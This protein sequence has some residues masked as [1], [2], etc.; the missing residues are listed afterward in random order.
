MAKVILHVAVL[1]SLISLQALLV[2]CQCRR[3]FAVEP[4]PGTNPL[5]C[6]VLEAMI[7]FT[8]TIDGTSVTIRWGFTTNSEEAGM[9]KHELD[10]ANDRYIFTTD[11]DVDSASAF[12]A[13]REFDSSYN[14]FYWCVVTNV[15]IEVGAGS[16]NPSHVLN[17]TAQHSTDELPPCEEVVEFAGTGERCA[18]GP[19]DSVLA[20]IETVEF[21]NE[22]LPTTTTEAPTTVTTETTTEE[23]TTTT[24]EK[25]EEATEAGGNDDV[26]RT[27][28]IW[29]SVGAAVLIL[30]VIG[31]I[32]CIV[33]MVKC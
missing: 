31:V 29:F 17:L 32:L 20:I 21:T 11:F 12:L 3:R 19:Q 28:I 23:M 4:R 6:N 7:T 27:A 15:G 25:T 26:V 2:Q 10:P 16:P 8:C 18:W 14:G 1:L 9:S 5:G 22:T 13:I 30:L 24:E 33:A